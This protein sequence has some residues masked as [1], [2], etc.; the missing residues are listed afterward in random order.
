MNV[1]LFKFPTQK[2]IQFNISPYGNNIFN[3]YSVSL[4][5]TQNVLGFGSSKYN[6]YMGSV[7]IFDANI[8]LGEGNLP[9]LDFSQGSDFYII[10]KLYTSRQTFNFINA[11]N[12][13][14]HGSIV[15]YFEDVREQGEAGGEFGNPNTNFTW[16]KGWITKTSEVLIDET[17][18]TVFNYLIIETDKVVVVENIGN[19]SAIV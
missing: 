19:I 13:G 3:G 2:Y 18:Y 10:S 7:S 4:S 15:M 14:Q 1:L 8:V 16:G 6:L 5:K 11:K 17:Q 9:V 12:I